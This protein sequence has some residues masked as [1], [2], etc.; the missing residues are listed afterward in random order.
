MLSV[1]QAEP[2]RGAT[3]RFYVR[4][5]LF[6]AGMGALLYGID[7]GIISAALLYLSRTVSLTLVQT[8]MVVAAVLGGSML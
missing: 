4:F 1:M 6:V 7:I 5:I 3:S 8:S 2:A